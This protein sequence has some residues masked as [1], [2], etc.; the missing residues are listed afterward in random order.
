MNFRVL[1]VHDFS[2]M[3][4]GGEAHQLLLLLSQ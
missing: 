1:M 2:D 4:A 3:V